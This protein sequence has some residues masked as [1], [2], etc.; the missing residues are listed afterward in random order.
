MPASRVLRAW[1]PVRRAALPV[2]RASLTIG[3]SRP[4][5]SRVTGRASR[6]TGQPDDAGVRCPPRSRVTGRRAA[7]RAAVPATPAWREPRSPAPPTLSHWPVYRERRHTAA[8][9]GRRPG[10]TGPRSGNGAVR[11][12]QVAADPVALAR[13]AGT[14]PSGSFRWPPTR[15]H[16]PAQPERHH[17]ATPWGRVAWHWRGRWER[18]LPDRRPGWASRSAG[19]P[20]D[21][22]PPASA[23]FPCD[24]RVCHATG[25]GASDSRV[26][27]ATE[28]GAC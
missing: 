23:A 5:R 2:Q 27:G 28:P 14:A 3:A 21:A 7:S 4:P 19:Q 24:G 15:P 18:Q 13:A 12:L 6:S 11:Q 8:S 17:A 16:W 25:S 20:D 10:R 9:G 1:L 26:A 22:G